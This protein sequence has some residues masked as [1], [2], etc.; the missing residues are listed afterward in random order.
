MAYLLADQIEQLLGDL[1][2]RDSDAGLIAE[3]CL[4]TGARWG[5][6]EKVQLRQVR[7][8]MVHYSRTKSSKNRSVPISKR[9]EDRLKAALPFRPCYITFGRSVA[10]IGLELPAGQMT[11]VLRHTF[12][13]HY[14][15]NGGDPDTSKGAWACDI[16]HDSKVRSLQSWASGRGRQS[17]SVGQPLG[18]ETGGR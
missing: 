14:M 10:A 3:V 6:A 4:A 8:K 1:A 15:M 18:G 11:H 16:G 7:N 5:E 12:A 2:T 9:L 13:S 17:E